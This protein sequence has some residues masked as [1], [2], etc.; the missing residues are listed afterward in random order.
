MKERGLA[1]PQTQSQIRALLESHGLS[2]SRKLGQNFLID[3]NLMAKLADSAGLAEADTVL[4][5]GP[6]TGS[7][8]ELLTER[9]GHVVAVEIDRGLFGL[10]RERF[11]ECDNLSLIHG[12]VLHSKSRIDPRVIELLRASRKTLAGRCCLVANLPY[13]SASPLLSGLLLSGLRLDLACFTVQKEVGDRI[14]ARPGGKEIGPLSIILQGGAEIERIAHVPPQAFW[15]QPEVQSVM[16]RMVPHADRT[17]LP[18]LARV[19]HECFLH[20]RKTL[21]YNIEAAFG[22]EAVERIRRETD[23]DLSRRPE[24]LSVSEWERLAGTIRVQ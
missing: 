5:V 7:L 15:P 14:V 10:L 4:E 13:G 8:T 16:L 18:R 23:L 9:A 19:V 17:G 22:L 6:G 2:P 24:T 21:R 20:R 12:D 11:E 1:I 3:G